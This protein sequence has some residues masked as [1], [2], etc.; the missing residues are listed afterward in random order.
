[1][2]NTEVLE[3]GELIVMRPTTSIPLQA[4][5][6][7]AFVGCHCS[8][9]LVAK[10]DQVGIPFASV[11]GLQQIS[12]IFIKMKNNLFCFLGLS[13]IG[14]GKM[15]LCENNAS[16]LVIFQVYSRVNH[17]KVHICLQ[18]LPMKTY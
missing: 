12:T 3:E 17:N 4:L 6:Y 7:K 18:E 13:I 14:I 15:F 8:L 1:M 9:F 11:R 2:R 16:C 10:Q 5:Q